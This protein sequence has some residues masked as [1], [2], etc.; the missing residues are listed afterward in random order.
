V[1]AKLRTCALKGSLRTCASCEWIF[2]V[3]HPEDGECP[4]CGF[5]HYGAHY[6]YGNKAYDYAK[7]QE[8][9]KNKKLAQYAAELDD[10]I[11]AQKGDHG[12]RSH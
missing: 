7:T 5:G 8:P 6:V 12:H 2:L 11:K 9:W 4:K 1:K 3:K 10:I